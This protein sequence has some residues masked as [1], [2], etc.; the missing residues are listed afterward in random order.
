MNNQ[1]AFEQAVAGNWIAESFNRPNVA[2]GIGKFYLTG[3]SKGYSTFGDCLSDGQVV[4]YAAFDDACN[5]EAGYG[6]FNKDDQSITPIES[7]ATLANGQYIDGDVAPIPFPDG[8]TITGTF[9]AVAFNAIWEHI[10]NKENPH[11]VIAEQVEQNNENGLGDN[12]QDALD[13]LSGVIADWDQSIQATTQNYVTDLP[14]PNPQVGDMWT[15]VGVTGEQY[16]WEGKYWV[17]VTGGGLGIDLNDPEALP[18]DIVRDDVGEDVSLYDRPLV[19]VISSATGKGTWVPI[20]GDTESVL[21]TDDIQ[22]RNPQRVGY[23]NQADAN[24]A[25]LSHIAKIEKEVD[26][27]DY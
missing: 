27:G 12:V 24:E 25:F 11:E 8:G 18:G 17:S 26:G 4:F 20:P 14:P 13:N 3:T 23:D 15:D 21:F 6:L 2:D 9:N 7:T 5:R 19:R 16:V 22:L 1:E 10:W